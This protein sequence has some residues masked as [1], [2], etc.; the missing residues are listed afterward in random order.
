[1]FRFSIGYF[2]FAVLLLFTEIFIAL[3]LHDRII[4]PYVGDFLVV[5]LIYCF[6]KTFLKYSHK[7]V[8]VSILLF[9]YVV[10]FLQ[11]FNLVSMLNLQ[12]S[13]FARVILGTSFEWIDM[14]AYT[15]GILFVLF[16]EKMRPQARDFH[17][18]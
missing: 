11:Y 4:R 5:I 15:L 9:A 17:K 6:I 1:M 14:L 10:E 13:E 3:Y 16:I 2:L 12:G 18:S 7:K 8:A